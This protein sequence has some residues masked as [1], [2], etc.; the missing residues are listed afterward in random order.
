MQATQSANAPQGPAHDRWIADIPKNSRETLRVQLSTFRGHE[1]ATL[2][3][4]YSPGNGD[5]LRPGKDG[6]AL[7]V[8]KL[9]ELR[10]AID[11][12]IAAARAEGTL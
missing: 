3:V 12:A 10:D 11:Q 9:P 2:R 6:F 4:W 1:L 5:E 7:R 8:E